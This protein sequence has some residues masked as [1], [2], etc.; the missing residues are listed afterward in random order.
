MRSKEGHSAP[1]E[2]SDPHLTARSSNKITQHPHHDLSTTPPTPHET[3]TMCQYL[4]IHQHAPGLLIGDDGPTQMPRHWKQTHQG[5]KGLATTVERKATSP[6]S[7]ENEPMRT[8]LPQ[9]EPQMSTSGNNITRSKTQS[10]APCEPNNPRSPQITSWI[11]HSRCSTNFQTTRR[12]H[13]YRSTKEGGRIFQM[14][15]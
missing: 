12:T 2:D 14:P 5:R 1:L 8:T 3:G 13:L 11:M 6:E 9:T 10:Y 4:W 15:N 7:A